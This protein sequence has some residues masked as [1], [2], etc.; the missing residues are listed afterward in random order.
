MPGPE[1]ASATIE[2]P[3]QSAGTDQ[4][5]DAASTRAAPAEPITWGDGGDVGDETA[6]NQTAEGDSDDGAAPDMAALTS[7]IDTA[8]QTPGE[9]A[10]TSSQPGTPAAKEDGGDAADFGPAPTLSEKALARL[11]DVL[12]DDGAKELA[13]EINATFAA[14]HSS[15]G[16]VKPTIDRASKDIQSVAER[17]RA[18]DAKRFD[19][20]IDA[21]FDKLAA[22][23][24]V[25]GTGDSRNRSA[26]RAVFAEADRIAAELAAKPAA[27]KA[28]KAKL[29]AG[30]AL[31]DVVLFKAHTAI[32]GNS[33]TTP[34]AVRELQQQV[35]SRS[36]QRT[37]Q[38]GGRSGRSGGDEDT[39]FEALTRIWKK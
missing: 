30:V 29:P 37:V 1:S 25:Y 35:V 33:P 13:D 4:T 8:M 3:A 20:Q 28:I 22:S 31:A 5:A 2:V 12:G 36:K 38:P 14:M 9:Q 10:Q 6:P 27:L 15:I 26:R 39:S 18:E 32:Y 11:A 7:M 21:K 24:P 19:E 34:D 17:Q 16:K 23:H